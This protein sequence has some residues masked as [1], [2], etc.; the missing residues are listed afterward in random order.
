MPSPFVNEAL[1]AAGG[2]AEVARA[3][4]VSSEAVRLWTVRGVPD[5]RVL[6]L[7]ERTG[8]KYTPHALAPTLYPHPDD[9]L[10]AGRRRCAREAA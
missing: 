6:W 9:G 5:K 1:V 2:I 10:P 3:L 7:A 4:R 8:W